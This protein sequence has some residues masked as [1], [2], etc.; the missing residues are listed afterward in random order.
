MRPA[1]AVRK[2]PDRMQV[3]GQLGIYLQGSF[4][5]VYRAALHLFRG[6]L[7]IFLQGKLLH[8]SSTPI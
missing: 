8:L 3:S 5:S 1:M 2:Q 6:Q 7:C 4:A